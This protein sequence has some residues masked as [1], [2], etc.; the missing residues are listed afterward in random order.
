M[1]EASPVPQLSVIRSLSFV[2]GEGCFS[3]EFMAQLGHARLLALV[4]QVSVLHC[5]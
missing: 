2:L 4:V 5:H 1:L 3:D